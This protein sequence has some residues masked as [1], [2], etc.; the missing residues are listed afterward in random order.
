MA[1]TAFGG[2]WEMTS[3]VAAAAGTAAVLVLHVVRYAYIQGQT[4]QRLK[5]LESAQGDAGEAHHVIGALTATVDALKDSVE[6]LDRALERINS[7]VFAAE[8]A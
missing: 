4:D 3:A 7:R 6:R 1:M 5:A 8:R 2:G